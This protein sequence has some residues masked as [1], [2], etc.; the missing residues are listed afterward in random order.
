[1]PREGGPRW[2]EDDDTATDKALEARLG[3]ERP[4]RSLQDL[5]WDRASDAFVEGFWPRAA[6]K[7]RDALVRWAPRSPT[8]DRF[9]VESADRLL[10][11]GAADLGDADLIP[12]TRA[13]WVRYLELAPQQPPVLRQARPGGPALVV[14]RPAALSARRRPPRR[15]REGGGDSR[16]ARDDPSAA[17]EGC[18]A[19]SD[20]SAVPADKSRSRAA[21]SDAEKEARLLKS[22]ADAVTGALRAARGPS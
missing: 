2:P 17:A 4:I 10:L 18:H 14:T 13:G 16:G 21:E 6:T 12:P 7:I 11:R 1:M 5:T 3:S 22:L 9:P 15:A 19:P 20:P 8:E